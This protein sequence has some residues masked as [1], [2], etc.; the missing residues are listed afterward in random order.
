MPGT[1]SDT[2]EA[3]TVGNCQVSTGGPRLIVLYSHCFQGWSWRRRKRF[4]NLSP[5]KG[6]KEGKKED[7][8]GKRV[9]SLEKLKMGTQAEPVWGGSSP[10][11]NSNTLVQY[12]TANQHTANEGRHGCLGQVDTAHLS[13]QPAERGRWVVGTY[14]MPGETKSGCKTL[15]QS[16]DFSFWQLLKC[17]PLPGRVRICADAG[18]FSFPRTHNI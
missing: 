16:A 9:R 12:L 10:Q 11:K 13:S 4:Q 17:S 3:I 14:L 2:H 15:L 8:T 5:G 18:S 7:T 1:V 6:R